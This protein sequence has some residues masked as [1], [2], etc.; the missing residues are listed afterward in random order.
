MDPTPREAL[1]ALLLF[2]ADAGVDCALDEVAANRFDEVPPVPLAGAR[3]S[4]RDRELQIPRE[5]A[6]AGPALVSAAGA[7]PPPDA[8][9]AA[10]SS[11][12]AACADLDALKAALE[13]FEGCA[14][15]ATASRTVFED[16]TRGARVMVVGE[17]PGREED[18]EG[19]PF[20]GKSGQLLDRMFAAI[21][22]S[23]A[24]LY[25]ANIVPWRPPGNRTPTP[26]EIR[27]CEPFIRRQIELAKPELLVCVGAPAMQ[28]LLE[29]SDGI[30][31]SRGRVVPYRAGDRMIRA[32]PILHP[33]YL[34]RTPIAKRQAWRDMLAIEELL[35]G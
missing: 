8:A 29:M 5:T 1:E 10:A 9:A 27:V 15:K 23:R 35:R 20:V 11:I 26:Q 25:I 34:L 3:S 33:A 19:K 4:S 21:G 6:P 22:M 31:R 28:S 2:Y 18:V 7:P 17:A 24:D 14:L 12:A 16:G 30:M 13:A 32:M